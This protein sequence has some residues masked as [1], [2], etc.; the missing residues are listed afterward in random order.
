MPKT[1]KGAI[2]PPTDDPLSKSATAQPRSDLGNH[3]DTVL[4]APG[5]LAASPQPSRNRKPMKLRRPIA[6]D[7]MAAATEYQLTVNRSPR[8][9][10]SQSSTRPETVCIRA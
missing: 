6:R 9:V 3:S 2:A 10:P 4:V 5:Q 1:R 8:R 7:V